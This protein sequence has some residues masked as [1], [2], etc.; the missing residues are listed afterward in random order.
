MVRSDADNKL[1]EVLPYRR[2]RLKQL[3]F[4]PIKDNLLLEEEFIKNQQGLKSQ[5]DRHDEEC[6]KVDYTRASIINHFLSVLISDR[7]PMIIDD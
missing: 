4:E 5:E 2:C 1:A 6:S 3:C 7:S